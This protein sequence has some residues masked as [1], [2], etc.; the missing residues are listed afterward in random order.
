MEKIEAIAA[1]IL[2]RGY[3]EIADAIEAGI[4]AGDLLPNSKLPNTERMVEIFQTSRVTIQRSLSRLAERGLVERAPRRGTLVAP[5]VA[6]RSFGILLGEDPI[7]YRHWFHRSLHSNLLYRAHE[8]ALNANTYVFHPDAGFGPLRQLEQDIADN[9]LKCLFVVC[10]SEDARRWL[11]HSCRIPFIPSPRLDLEHLSAEGLSVL[12]R[13][14]YRNIKVLS[15]AVAPGNPVFH[16]EERGLARAWSQ[17]GMKGPPPELIWC[18][19][20]ESGAYEAT[21]RCC[22][23]PDGRPDAI[24]CLHD[25]VTRGV[26]FALT[27]LG[28]K[29]PDDIGLLTHVCSGDEPF[30][31]VA[32]D[33]MAVDVEDV[34]LRT[35][36]AIGAGLGR[37]KIG[38]NPPPFTFQAQYRAGRSLRY[39]R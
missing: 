7:D 26:L 2:R 13:R 10:V 35:L 28:L 11:D 12:L 5:G 14:G 29:M 15:M 38:A 6:S 39:R 31:L 9:R 21:R 27:E 37:L 20:T 24:Y 17:H 1:G 19:H 30:S 36:G 23:H 4:L 34:A 25:I 22:L 3:L 16:A 18:G 32:L 33:A 8:Y